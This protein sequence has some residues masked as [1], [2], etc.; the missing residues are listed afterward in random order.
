MKKTKQVNIAL[1]EAD[2]TALET[3]ADKEE[4]TLSD[5]ARRLIKKG[6]EA[7]KQKGQKDTMK[8]IDLRTIENLKEFIGIIEKIGGKF[9]NAEKGETLVYNKDGKPTLRVSHK[10][11]PKIKYLI[12]CALINS[13]TRKGK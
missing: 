6:L 7:T 9:G 13:R 8:T 3:L 5:T 1:T 2:Y 12:W 11:A 4:R 10:N